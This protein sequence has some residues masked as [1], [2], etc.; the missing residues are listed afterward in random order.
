MNPKFN[1]WIEIN[2]QVALSVWRVKLLE[3]IAQTGSISA[4]AEKVGVPYRIAWQKIHEMEERL[5]E[6]LVETQTGGK[7]GGG[8]TL[9]PLALEYIGKFNQFNQEAQAYLQKRYQETFGEM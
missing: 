1:L 8:T 9:T 7:E 3:A 4:G 2:G 5:G 6:K